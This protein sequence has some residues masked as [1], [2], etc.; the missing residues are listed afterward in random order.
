MEPNLR[1]LGG[2]DA[3]LELGLGL[4]IGSRPS[5]YLPEAKSP[6]PSCCRG[7]PAKIDGAVSGTQRA[8]DCVTRIGTKTRGMGQ[9]VGWP[10]IRSYRMNS[11]VNHGK[12][13]NGEDNKN[14]EKSEENSSNKLGKGKK[15]DNG[16]FSVKENGNLGFVKVNMDG[17]PIGRKVDL[18]AHTSYQSLAEALV[19]MFKS[20]TSVMSSFCGEKEQMEMTPSKLLDGS[21]EFALTYE[22]KEGDWLLVGDVPWGMFVG[23]AKRLRILRTS[24]AKG[25]APTK[26]QETHERRNGSRI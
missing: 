14:N 26:I 18:T 4:N 20:A 5:C 22:D 10:P 8:P 17:I 13:P 7:K 2:G 1:L 12:T 24:E 16:G 19:A 6:G 3:G 11:L 25:L 21:S 15:G 23:A 9:V